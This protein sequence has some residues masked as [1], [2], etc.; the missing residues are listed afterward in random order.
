MAISRRGAT[1]DIDR[2]VVPIMLRGVMRYLT[3]IQKEN[4]ELR[5]K[6][7]PKCRRGIR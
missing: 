5:R 1:S 2:Y 6:L 3:K 4:A 7:A